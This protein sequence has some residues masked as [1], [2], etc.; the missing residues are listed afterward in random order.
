MSRPQNPTTSWV[1][2]HRPCPESQLRLFCFPFAGGGASSYR[3]WSHELSPHIEVVPVQPPGRENRYRE[4]PIRQMENLVEELTEALLPF[5]TDKPFAFF[6]H[7]LGAIVALE[8]TRVFIKRAARSPVHL[9]ISARPAPHLPLRRVPVRNLSREQ[10]KN[11]LGQVDGTP[12]AVLESEEM[13]DFVLPLLR[14]DLEI[15]D[16]YLT[17]PEPV[18]ACPLTVLGGLRDG[19]ATSEE[20]KPW[21][22][23][24]R[25][26]FRLRLME[27]GHFFPFNE[28]RSS[29]LA[30]ITEALLQ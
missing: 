7:S 28:S 18:L 20:L 3:S 4:E 14:A 15:D 10:F 9:L 21:S 6:G 22:H 24:T 17:T 1:A 23:Y 25:G 27:G 11:W 8:A 19:Q 12:K 2:L 30:T 29:V 26:R 16:G 5:M 13:M